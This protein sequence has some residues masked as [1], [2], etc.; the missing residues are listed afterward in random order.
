[1]TN[2]ILC[3]VHVNERILSPCTILALTKDRTVAALGVFIRKMR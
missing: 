2:D 3:K 1:M